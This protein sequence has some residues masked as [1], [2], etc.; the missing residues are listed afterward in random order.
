MIYFLLINSFLFF[1]MYNVFKSQLL[2]VF[3]GRRTHCLVTQRV[4]T[5][6]Q[7]LSSR[8]CGGVIMWIAV[9]FWQFLRSCVYTS[10]RYNNGNHG[11]QVAMKYLHSSKIFLES[12]FYNNICEVYISNEWMWATIKF[13][14]RSFLDYSHSAIWPYGHEYNKLVCLLKYWE[15]WYWF[16]F[17]FSEFLCISKNRWTS[18][19]AM[20][21]FLLALDMYSVTSSGE[22]TLL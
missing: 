7:G 22:I 11:N 12:C 2:L 17:Y 20:K 18:F 14:D 19:N 13:L 5:C 4:Q 15:I 6:F 1:I 3:C 8:H 10:G 9:L 16:P 21:L